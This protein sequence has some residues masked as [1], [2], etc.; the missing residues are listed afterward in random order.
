VSDRDGAARSKRRVLF[1]AEAVTLAHVARLVTLAKSLD[2]LRYDVCLAADNRYRSVLGDVPFPLRDIG[3]IAKAQ[4]SD[5]L[6]RGAP[7]YTKKDLIGYVEE[8]RRLID[9]FRP[10]L[11]VGDFRLS[12]NISAALSK[13]PYSTVTNAYWSPYALVDVPVPEIAL[14]RVLGVRAAQLVFD[15]VRPLAFAFHAVPLNQARKHYGLPPLPYD[16]RQTYTRADYTLYADIPEQVPTRGLP[17][18][19]KYIGPVLWS[20]ATPLP[21]WW[22]GLPIDKPLIYVTLGSSGMGELLPTVLKAL[23]TFPAIVVAATAGEAIPETIPGNARVASYLP[24]Q[25]VASRAALVV[26]NGGSPTC[27][28]GLVAGRPVLGIADNLDQLLNMETLMRRGLGICLRARRASA[29][30]IAAAVRKILDEP[31]I[32]TNAERFAV[33]FARYDAPRLFADHVGTCFA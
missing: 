33:S 1:V 23:Q 16:L 11:V 28:Q 9:A 20:P 6:A 25:A 7:L 26:C 2:P 29:D 5:A 15:V 10:D 13:V 3:T 8:D 30:T 32:R 19:H 17:P 22:S 4:F 21:E 14:T 24:G 27:Q 18:N 12:L 31:E